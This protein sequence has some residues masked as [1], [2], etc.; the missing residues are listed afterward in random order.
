VAVFA[1]QFL[2]FLGHVLLVERIAAP[3]LCALYFPRILRLLV[4]AVGETLILISVIL[5]YLILI[6][7]KI[8]N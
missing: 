7:Q 6:Q 5:I 8:S 1:T 3:P 4:H 2:A